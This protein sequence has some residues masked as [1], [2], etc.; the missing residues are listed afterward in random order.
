[1]HAMKLNLKGLSK[2]V[3]LK[4]IMNIFKVF[5]LQWLSMEGIIQVIFLGWGGGGGYLHRL[6]QLKEETKR[7]TNFYI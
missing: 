6:H 5:T 4:D 7:T 2:E 3:I 1:M